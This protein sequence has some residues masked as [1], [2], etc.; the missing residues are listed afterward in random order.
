M[1]PFT[2]VDVGLNKE[3]CQGSLTQTVDF[4]R[5]ISLNS[6]STHEAGIF[7]IPILQVSKLR[8]REAKCNLY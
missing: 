5:V 2:P 4:H 1:I 3:I 7:I 6:S 8:H